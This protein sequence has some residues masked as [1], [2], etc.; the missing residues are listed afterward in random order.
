MNSNPII[1]PEK[2]SRWVAFLNGE[3]EISDLSNQE[4]QDMIDLT[5]VWEAAGTSFSNSKANPDKAWSN[6]QKELNLPKGN[7]KIKMFK[8]HILKYAA[9]ILFTIA[10]GFATYEIVK[11]PVRQ[12]DKSMSMAV[13]TTETH[14]LN[15]TVVTLPDGST[16]K[17]NASTRI[18]Y[19]LTFKGKIRKVKLSGEA[20]FE[21]TRDTL[22]PFIIETK[23]ASVEVLGTSFNVSAY[24]N[25]GLVEVNVKTGKVKLTQHISGSSV[26]KSAILPAGERGW[27][28]VNENSMGQDRILSPNYSAW[29]TKEIIFQR[30]PLAQAFGV[31]EDTYHVKIRMENPQIGKIPYTANFY[32]NQKLDY[33]IEVIARTHKLKVERKADEI[34]FVSKEN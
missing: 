20:F 8:S 32:P 18:E 15:F 2:E 21:V 34:I 28:N 1:P 22:R 9:M 29:I 6:L 11:T 26:H 23:N 24:P 12:L 13:L 33:I 5:S 16:V 4:A 14:P 17:M 27:V 19:P 3:P 10:V 30:T 31:L 25:A 7:L